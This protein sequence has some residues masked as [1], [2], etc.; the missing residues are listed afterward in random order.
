MTTPQGTF[1]NATT[2]ET[3]TRPLTPEEIELLPKDEK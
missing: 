2:G 1:H 3:I